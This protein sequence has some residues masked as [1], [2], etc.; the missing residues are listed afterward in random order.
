MELISSKTRSFATV[1]LCLDLIT[2]SAHE[3]LEQRSHIDQKPNVAAFQLNIASA[4]LARHLITLYNASAAAFPLTK[5]ATTMTSGEE[6]PT[7]AENAKTQRS[8][9][10]CRRGTSSCRLLTLTL[11]CS[12]KCQTSSSGHSAE[13]T[14]SAY[15]KAPSNQRGST[16][17]LG[18]ITSETSR[19]T[20]MAND[21][22]IEP[23]A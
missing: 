3:P 19:T 10:R 11:S 18:D 7:S 1:S 5:K 12:A 8:R 15:A 22:W 6:V 20:M 17:A 4:L 14:A 2:K 16:R 21:Q 9:H 13:E 23:F